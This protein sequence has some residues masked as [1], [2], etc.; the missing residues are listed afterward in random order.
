MLVSYSW[1]KISNGD[2]YGVITEQL[3]EQ[4]S[5]FSIVLKV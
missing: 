2:I 3:N 5:L 1:N 4:E